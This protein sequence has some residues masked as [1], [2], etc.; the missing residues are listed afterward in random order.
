LEAAE[1]VKAG[2]FTAALASINEAVNEEPENHQYL[3]YKGYILRNTGDFKNALLCMEKAIEINSEV[4]WYYAEA[5]VCAYTMHDLGIA[6][7]YSSR[8]I[9]FGRESL[10]A[11][12][13]DYVKTVLENL[14]PAE[15]TLNFRFNP[16]NKKLVY[17]NDG[18]LCIPVPSSGLPYQETKYRI[19]NAEL[20]RAKKDN[21]FDL[22]YIKPYGKDEVSVECTIRKTP[23][24][25]NR[26]IE[27]WDSGKEIP[28]E[29]RKYLES[30]DRVNFNSE[31]V[32]SA[33]AKIKGAN[34]ID[35]VNNIMKW[36]NSTKRKGKAPV[37][38]TA[39]D[40]IRGKDVECAT[41]SL[42]VVAIARAC[43]IPARQVWG[44]IDAGRGYSPENYL[45]GHVWF[46]FYLR[47]AGWIPAEQFDMSSV[48]LLPS[49]YIRMMTS[50]THLFDNVPLSNIMTIMHNDKWGDIIEYRKSVTGDE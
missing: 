14:K 8:A 28:S 22:I 26:E 27:K 36:I 23:Y 19:I 7:K 13:Y 37:W 9:S 1:K 44:P 41:G 17:E 15:Y 34:D 3:A 21:D 24:S 20:L 2:N 33:A 31:T 12:N 40:I 4:S 47:G 38:K 29:I 18:T 39:D 11:V 16:G 10:G 42:A 30:S 32:K 43:G 45:K 25:Y 46:E 6:K 50:P 48:G 49:S 5:V 35:T